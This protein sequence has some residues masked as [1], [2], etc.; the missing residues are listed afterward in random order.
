VLHRYPRRLLQK[1]QNLRGEQHAAGEEDKETRHAAREEDKE[2]RGRCCQKLKPAG[3][4]LGRG[5]IIRS[6]STMHFKSCIMRKDSRQGVIG[7]ILQSAKQVHVATR[8][9]TISARNN[10][11]HRHLTFATHDANHP[12]KGEHLHGARSGHE[13]TCRYQRMT[14][15]TIL[16]LSLSLHPSLPTSLPTHRPAC[17]PPSL[18][19][20]SLS[21]CHREC[22]H[23]RVR[24]CTHPRKCACVHV[25]LCRK[26]TSSSAGTGRQ[27]EMCDAFL[28]EKAFES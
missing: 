10:H 9:D 24:A 28:R 18:P 13:R 1:R 7:R 3:E 21:L 25:C 5:A 11:T 23:A 15:R 20:S 27:R 12:V 6:R 14:C 2:T 26:T 16:N 17:L 19:P 8:I 22:V 4:T